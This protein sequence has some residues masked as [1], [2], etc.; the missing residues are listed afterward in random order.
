MNYKPFHE[1]VAELFVKNLE[2]E[3]SPFR[4]QQP[5]KPS[6][7]QTPVNASTGKNYRGLNALWLSM[8]P[9][10]DPRWMTMQQAN[11]MQ[12]KIPKGSSG[13]ILNIVK[14][15]ESFPMLDDNGKRIK[16][17]QGKIKYHTVQLEK[18]IEETHWVFNASQLAVAPNLQKQPSAESGPERLAKFIAAAGIE[19]VAHKKNEEAYDINLDQIQ[20]AK[21]PKHYKNQEDYGA[22]LLVQLAAWTAHPDRLNRGASETMS[23]A[24]QVAGQLKTGIATLMLGSETG[25]NS[26]KAD[27]FEKFIPEWISM[28]KAEP[29][30]LSRA[31]NDAQKIV[32]YI[33]EAETKLGLRQNVPQKPMRLDLAIGDEINYS[34][35]TYKVIDR[36]KGDKLKI[37]D[38]NTGAKLPISPADGLYKS[39]VQ[40]KY[41]GDTV[42]N[43]ISNSQG[44][45]NGQPNDLDQEQS[46]TRNIRR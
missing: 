36:I 20:V 14:T 31:A 12:I 19:V 17:E 30:V 40:A 29:A 44:M 24:D 6:I 16:D 43:E 27:R 45:E 13:T 22:A 28:I 8:Q 26:Y 35:T 10:P 25:I 23:I 33:L 9:F 46:E 34:G 18:P 15:S 37:E 21:D 32:D 11:K 1:K 2:S 42:S 4:A 41:R 39:L 7:F 38:V 5:D 3:T